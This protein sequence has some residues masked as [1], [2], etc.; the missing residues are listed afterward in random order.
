MDQREDA[1]N[2]QT[3]RMLDE[4]RR[5]TAIAPIMTHKTTA[6]KR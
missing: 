4:E 2:A 5:R 3:K 6:K 1:D